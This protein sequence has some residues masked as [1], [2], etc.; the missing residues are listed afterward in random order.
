MTGHSIGGSPSSITVPQLFIQALQLSWSR[1]WRVQT[2]S[3]VHQVIRLHLVQI[4]LDRFLSD[5]ASAASS[6]RSF[7]VGAG[8]TA[9]IKV[10]IISITL[11][12]YFDAMDSLVG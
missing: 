12:P 11:C 6:Q 1:R 5:M 8:C 4:L 9:F 7:I 3:L 2:K 10:C